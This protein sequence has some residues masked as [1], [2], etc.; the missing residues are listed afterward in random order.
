MLFSHSTVVYGFKVYD[1]M[2]FTALLSKLQYA[3]Y[4]YCGLTGIILAPNA[5]QQTFSTSL[6]YFDF[7]HN[8]IVGSVPTQV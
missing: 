1:I 3:D 2:R 7:S 8:L 5:P 4:S 6:Q